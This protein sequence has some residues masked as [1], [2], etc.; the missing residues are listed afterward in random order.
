MSHPRKLCDPITLGGISLPNRIVKSAMVEGLADA[1][2]RATDRLVTLYEAWAKAGVGLCI[3]GMAYVLDGWS[4]TPHELGMH[5]D[6]VIDPFRRVTQAVHRHGGRIFVQLCHAP[7][8]ILRSKARRLGSLA[9]SPGLNRTNLLQDRALF[10]WEILEIAGAFGAAARRAREAA[11]DGIE[12][13]GA[14]GYLISRFLSPRH[15]RRRDR[16]GGSREARLE[17][18]RVIMTEVHRQAGTDFPVLLKLNA[19]DGEAGGLTLDESVVMAQTL[20]AWGIHGIEVSAGTADVGLSFYPNKGGVPLDLGKAFLAKE[21]PWLRPVLPL[22]GPVL[23]RMS[24]RVALGQEGYF[25]TEARR[26]AEALEIPV[27]QVG[28]I[29]T[30]ETAER[31]LAESRVALVALGRP[32]VRRPSLPSDWQ[33]GRDPAPGCTSCNRCFV[34]IGLGEALACDRQGEV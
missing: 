33:A 14:H 24:R 9:P 19:H 10:E 21:F 27:I 3:T 6:A 15:N 26:F 2:G 32:L 20:P 22:A 25:G 31:I 11:A 17:L 28:G 16:W 1:Q 29:R 30:R 34:R 18:L 5:D 12:L 7:P 8:Q 13:H 4:L 23:A